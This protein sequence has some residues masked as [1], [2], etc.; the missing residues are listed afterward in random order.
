MPYIKHHAHHFNPKNLIEYV[1]DK[2]KNPDLKLASGVNCNA[3]VECAYD[4]FRRVFEKFSNE[5]FYSYSLKKDDKYKRIRLHHYIQSFDPKD[6]LSPE[7]AHKIGMEWA[8]KV[9]GDK[10]Q[11]ICSTHLDKLHVHNHFIVAPYDFSGKMWNDNKRTLNEIRKSSD[12][13]CLKHGVSI[14]ENTAD[15]GKRYNEWREAKS[16]R[17]W[18]DNLRDKIDFL[19][20]DSKITTLDDL[21]DKLQADGCK[22]RRG[23]FISV[24]PPEAE[25]AVRLYRLGNGYSEEQL[26][27]RLQHK[28][29]ETSLASIMSRYVGISVEYALVLRQVELSVYKKRPNPKRWNYKNLMD[30]AELL[31]FVSLNHIKSFEQFERLAGEDKQANTLFERYKKELTD[32]YTRIFEQIREERREAER[33]LREMK[34]NEEREKA[35][36]I[37]RDYRGYSR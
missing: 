1:L 18:K 27:F 34:R 21:M 20:A 2:N 37:Q 26:K 29:K 9:W 31:S 12:E 5:K 35:R 8:R 33:I 11:Y 22:I 14:I 36:Q 4:E 10:R 32:D 23:K 3:D 28:D 30:G 15:K 16:G 24:K 6:N 19:I 17:S 25:R 13:V 7:V